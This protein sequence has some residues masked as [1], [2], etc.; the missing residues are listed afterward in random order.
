MRSAATR[1]RSSAPS[2]AA[3][4]IIRDTVEEAQK[5]A[6]AWAERNQ[7]PDWRN[8]TDLQGPAELVAERWAPYLDLG[9]DHVYVDCPAPFDHETLERLAREVKPML[10]SR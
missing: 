2:R 7:L 8:S 9:F 6:A 3:T 5:V 10:E 1:P 4:P